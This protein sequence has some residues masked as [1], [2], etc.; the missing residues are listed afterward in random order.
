MRR[1][2]W[3][4]LAI[5]SISGAAHADDFAAW[6]EIVPP[7]G[8]AAPQIRAHVKNPDGWR[9]D[10]HVRLVETDVSPHV[11][12]APTSIAPTDEPIAVAILTEGHPLWI[13]VMGLDGSPSTLDAIARGAPRGSIAQLLVYGDGTVER[14]P[15]IA[16]D[17]LR[18]PIDGHLLHD[19]IDKHTLIEGFAR[20]LADLRDVKTSRKALIVI[21]DGSDM[22]PDPS[23]PQLAELKKQFE[24]AGI[25]LYAIYY[26]PRDDGD[27]S[28]LKALVG[29]HLHTANSIENFAAQ[30]S[31]IMN[32]LDDGFVVTFP[33]E[34]LTWDG[35]PHR[36]DLHFGDS[37]VVGL[38]TN[39]CCS[40]SFA[41]SPRIWPWFLL[42]AGVIVAIGSIVLALRMREVASPIARASLRRG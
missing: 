35:K 28:V 4:V 6:L 37:G 34:T 33:G 24:A 13:Q 8:H 12:V 17:R 25:R 18:G 41:S 5:V 1:G 7:T 22:E 40:D 9:D 31:A 29:V 23:K 20:A 42:V 30:A 2:W 14:S 10:A 26:S 36:F 3:L 38:T 19:Q 11:S 16:M 21:G 39:L 27:A 32:E 15:F